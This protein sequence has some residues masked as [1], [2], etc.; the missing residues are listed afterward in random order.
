MLSFPTGMHSKCTFDK[1]TKKYKSRTNLRNLKKTR[2]KRFPP[3]NL[4]CN[5]SISYYITSGII[6]K[7]ITLEV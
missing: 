5:A 4:E 2:F 1:N 6:S 7:S 3:K